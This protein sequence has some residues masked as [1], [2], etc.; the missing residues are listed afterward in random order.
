M[1]VLTVVN[2]ACCV[3]MAFINVRLNKKKKAELEKLIADNGWTEEDVQR[4]REKAAFLD[5][6]DKENVFFTYTR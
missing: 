6:T 4:E 3:L 1:V 2:M 5:L